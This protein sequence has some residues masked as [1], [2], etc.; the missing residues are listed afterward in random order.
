MVLVGNLYLLNVPALNFTNLGAVLIMLYIPL[1]VMIGAGLEEG[2]GRLPHKYYRTA[3]A[4]LIVSILAASL[5]A[6]YARATTVEP[7]RHF[8]TDQDIAAM[9]WIDEHIPMDATFAINTYYW[10]PRFAHGTD[11]GY[12]IPYFTQ[13]QI[14]TTSMLSN[15]LEKEYQQRTQARSKAAESLESDLNALTTLHDLGV[16]YIYIGA[17]GDFSGPG[18]QLDF[19]TQSDIVQV[20]YNQGGAAILQILPTDTQ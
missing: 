11:A 7:Y 5:P 18:L 4:V 14:V 20:L 10:L 2:L 13:R 15:G 9:Q 8:V 6:T 1:S 3:L 16:D 17:I 19:L 12:W